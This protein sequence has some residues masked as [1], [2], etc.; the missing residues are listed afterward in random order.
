MLPHH[1]ALYP[2]IGVPHFQRR[3]LRGDSAV[4]HPATQQVAARHER[5][6]QALKRVVG[7]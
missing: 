5:L 7:W 4:Q 6:R 1:Q 3:Y 2:A